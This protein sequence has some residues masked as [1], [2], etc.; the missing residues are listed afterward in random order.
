MGEEASGHPPFLS[1]SLGSWQQ[2][3]LARQGLKLAFLGGYLKLHFWAL[4]RSGVPVLVTLHITV[5]ICRT[6]VTQ[7]G[8]ALGS[9]F[10]GDSPSR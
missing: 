5:T 4:M 10:E 6:K 3:G 8:I 1:M 2:D 9:P 7:G